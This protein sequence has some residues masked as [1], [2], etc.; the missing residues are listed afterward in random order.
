MNVHADLP[1]RRTDIRGL[2]SE[3]EKKRDA[4]AGLIREAE[5]AHSALEASSTVRG[6]YVGSIWGRYGSPSIRE[7]GLQEN[8][9]KSAWQEA[10]HMLHLDKIAPAADREKWRLAMENPPTF[11]L[12]N[13]VATFG[14]YIEDPRHHILR[15]LAEAFA[16]LDPFFRSHSKV[17]VGKKG[18]P[19]RLIFTSVGSHSGSY[20][21]D[22]LRDTLNAVRV[23]EGE[24]HLTHNEL[25]DMLLGRPTR[26]S[27]LPVWVR[28]KRWGSGSMV[29]YDGQ[30][31]IADSTIYPES[32]FRVAGIGGSIG[33]RKLTDPMPGIEIKRFMNG[34][35]HV[36]FDRDRL[37]QINRALAEFYGEVLPD[38]VVDPGAPRPSREVSTRLQFYAT[39][40]AVL[41]RIWSRYDRHGP[42]QVL[43]PSA[44]EGA[45]C[46]FIRE[47]WPQAEI[48][49]IEVDQSRHEVLREKMIPARRANFLEVPP[50]PRFDLILMN[51]PFH[52]LHWKKHIEHARG[53]LKP[54]DPEHRY[55]NRGAGLLVCILPATA[56]YDGH[57]DGI[58]G[59]WEDLP[60]A[61]FAEA[62][63]NVP[64]G[65][66]RVWG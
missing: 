38:V 16:G 56:Y 46:D 26:I 18:L 29:E 51:P 15:G 66:F 12:E 42:G 65:Y 31:W 5:E 52:G 23:F 44:G 64:T 17:K 55:G 19:K 62:G 21:F 35:A 43:E 58:P 20:G 7:D 40:R 47:V 53:F 4:L 22:R 48:T 13:M 6:R 50:D 10:F 33:W 25:R 32:E 1:A 54:H 3:Y 14:K 60:V 39:P 9:L 37:I 49:A 61:S 2:I 36:H 27:D 57:L 59:A 11:T 30:A 24:P 41:D 34:N 45:I 63:T 28:D 8:L